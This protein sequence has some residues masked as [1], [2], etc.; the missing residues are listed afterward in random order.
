[1][2]FVTTSRR[3]DLISLLYLLVF[4]INGG[5]LLDVDLNNDIDRN[6]AFLEMKKLK[7]KSSI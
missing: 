4:L 6:Q 1:M 2:D 7:L 3:D 5:N